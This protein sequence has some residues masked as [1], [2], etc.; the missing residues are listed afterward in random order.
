MSSL[1]DRYPIFRALVADV[2]SCQLPKG[3]EALTKSRGVCVDDGMVFINPSERITALSG[4]GVGE[5][6]DRVRKI[7]E[8][9]RVEKIKPH[10]GCGKA[11]LVLVEQHGVARPSDEQVDQFAQKAAVSLGEQIGVQV[12]RMIGF[13]DGRKTMLTR[14]ENHH[15]ANQAIVALSGRLPH[16]LLPSRELKKLPS[17]YNLEG[18][19]LGVEDLR[20]VAI[21]EMG[22]VVS[23][24]SG[25]HG[26]GIV[27]ERFQFIALAD[28]QDRDLQ[29]KLYGLQE[30]FATVEDVLEVRRS[31]GERLNAVSLD[32]VKYE[33]EPRKR[34]AIVSFQ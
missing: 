29:R 33:I 19:Y 4:V 20:A 12:G 16:N 3:A 15:P 11:R 1:K 8:M 7:Y 27:P 14:P 30:V 2:G 21:G 17:H 6:P 10:K 13:N 9:T 26:V 28:Q 31:S 25:A 34:G 5:V 24:A 23:I 32:I 18:S 22:L